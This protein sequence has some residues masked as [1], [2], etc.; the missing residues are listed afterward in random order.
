MNNSLVDSQ[1]SASKKNSAIKSS[2]DKAVVKKKKDSKEANEDGFQPEFDRSGIFDESQKGQKE[3]PNRKSSALSQDR[4]N[5]LGPSK[6][7]GPSSSNGPLAP[8]KEQVGKAARKRDANA[9][10]SL[11]TTPKI[12]EESEQAQ[13]L[14]PTKRDEN[15]QD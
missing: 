9:R 14:T 15:G 5:A 12:K 11:A 8:I 3:K 1:S 4:K 13:D 2:K 6:N 10:Q 7:G